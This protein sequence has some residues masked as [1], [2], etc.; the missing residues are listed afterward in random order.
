MAGGQ[1]R[2]TAHLWRYALLR[3][4]PAYV[5]KIADPSTEAELDD[6]VE[7]LTDEL[8]AD[9]ALYAPAEG[10]AQADLDLD[11]GELEALPLTI[12]LR[13]HLSATDR[14]EGLVKEQDVALV[15]AGVI[16][17]YLS[18][19]ALDLD[20]S[21]DTSSDSDASTRA[22]ADGGG[23]TAFAGNGMLKSGRRR[24]KCKLCR[25][26]GMPLTFHHLVPKATHD[27][28]LDRR[29]LLL[30]LP[31]SFPGMRTTGGGVGK[32]RL[33]ALLAK[34]TGG[35]AAA[36]GGGGASGGS[37]GRKKQR[38]ER[39]AAT[40]ARRQ[41]DRAR[42]RAVDR[43]R[44]A[45]TGRLQD[46]PKLVDR[47]GNVIDVDNL[48]SSTT[49]PEPAEG[50]D[51]LSTVGEPNDRPSTTEQPESAKDL[52]PKEHARQSSLVTREALHAYGAMLCRPCHSHVHRTVADERVL[53]RL[54]NT[55][56]KLLTL[57]ALQKWQAWAGTQRV[58]DYRTGLATSRGLTYRR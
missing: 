25:R 12:L 1:L 58:S 3:T 16:E 56:D 33:A 37:S 13:E 24:P 4:L 28:F 44:D 57:D 2:D 41:E 43:H 9:A 11:L 17:H 20:A 46:K 55:V 52:S 29:D 32:D 53:G 6:V 50:V 27:Y 38:D 36:G 15:A 47:L 42:L 39:R 5:S 10:A 23:S 45:D 31:S 8:S 51:G 26:R 35:H 30:P 54:Y 19:V 18:A 40:K 7:L 34:E 49:A 22:A 48:P 14:A 21:S